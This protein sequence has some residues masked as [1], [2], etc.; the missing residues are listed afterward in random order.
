MVL[1]IIRFI[2]GWLKNKMFRLRNDKVMYFIEV[3]FCI[4]F[5]SNLSENM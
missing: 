4:I 5:V 1:F 2:R 3:Y